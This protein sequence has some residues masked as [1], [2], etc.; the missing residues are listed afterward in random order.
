MTQRQAADIAADRQRILDEARE[1]IAA[2]KRLLDSVGI[3]PDA[4]LE[5]LRRSK[6]D[7]AAAQ[8]QREVDDLLRGIDEE[9][10]Q[11]V[12]HAPKGRPASR[13]LAQ[14]GRV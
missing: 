7:A 10:Q 13:H 1:A 14:R 12:L 3:T 6:G 9:V 2:S 8:V 5:A 11:H 4:C